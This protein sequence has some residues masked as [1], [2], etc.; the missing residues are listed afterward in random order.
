MGELMRDMRSVE[1]LKGTIVPVMFHL[2]SN[3]AL[4]LFGHRIPSACDLIRS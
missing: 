3:A 1:C 2:A 4:T